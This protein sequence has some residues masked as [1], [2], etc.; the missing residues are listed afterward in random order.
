V[1][2][3][4]SNP[5]RV[6]KVTRPDRSAKPPA[7]AVRKPLVAKA[8][9]GSLPARK[10]RSASSLLPDF[11]PFTTCLLVDHAPNGPDWVHEIKLDGWRIQIRVEEEQARSARAMAT[12]TAPHFPELAR[13]ARSF[14]N[15]IIDGEVC[16]VRKDGI[17]DFSSLQVAMK[18]GKTAAL[19]RI[20]SAL[21]WSRTFARCL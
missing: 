19:L 21:A 10:E 17:T 13:I 5:E 7:K 14:D 8:L 1:P 16:S 6:T 9:L 18:A 15:C 2:R 4:R 12:I 11:I 3:P 20:R